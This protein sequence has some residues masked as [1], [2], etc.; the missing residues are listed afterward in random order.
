MTTATSSNI[1]QAPPSTR[2]NWAQK[3]TYMRQQPLIPVTLLLLLL[4]MCVFILYPIYQIVSQSVLIDGRFSLENYI[5]FFSS[6]FFQHTLYNTVVISVIATISAVVL[7]F[8]FA[9]GITRTSMPGKKF[10]MLI[11]I[12]PLI[13]PPFF[14]AFAFILLLGRQGI[15]NK[16]LF[17][18]FGVR[19]IIFGWQGVVLAQTIML[20][21]IAFLNLSAALGSIDPRMEEAAEDMGATFGVIMRRVTLPLLIPSLFSSAILIFMFNL[22][23]FGIPAIL[24]SSR[25]IWEDGSMLAPEAII[26]I[27][28]VFN[29]GM[30]AALAMVMLIPSFI[31][32]IFQDW[33]VRRRSYITVTGIPTSYPH[34]LAPKSVK[35][36]GFTIC[37][38]AAFM[39][40][41]IYVVVFMGAITRTW[42]V[43]YTLTT[44][45]I[46]LMLKVGL[47]SIRNSLVLSMGG[48]L[49]ASTLGV[50]IAFVLSRWEFPGK[51]S[52]Q[53]I[54]MLPYALPGVVMGLGFAVGF[55]SGILV[56]TGTWMIII[57]N[58]AI[59]R[60]PFSIESN[61]SAL[62]QIDI[63][64]EEAAA[65]MGASWVTTFWQIVLP[66]LRPTFIAALAFSFI[67]E[68]TDIT[69]VI[70][71]VSP[72]WRLLSIDIYNN[73]TAGRVGVAS[74]MSAT[75][76]VIV[77][78]VL[79]IIWRVS[80]LG[81]RMFK[82]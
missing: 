51:R 82:L 70:F 72:H 13:T 25:L 36:V 21:P 8:V 31:L 77:I 63:T 1:S 66:L 69:A 27:L 10:F 62:A 6:R 44:R 53:F 56:L 46:E 41:S 12:L 45:H 67:K 17:S 50:L 11:S 14:S 23:S 81:Y 32:F 16:V 38:L 33:Y 78:G 19:W 52:F 76:V 79:A 29:W 39:V 68:M 73:I 49:I 4:M 26:Q 59:R 9:F 3:Y 75:M 58:F 18:L 28:G 35:W 64:L 40:I 48:A 30:G 22:S 20:F 34:R 74:A 65:D 71:L 47:N 43:D 37:S 57:L 5:T 80:G 2:K 54:A 7:G 55:N 24:G 60:M 42:G 61:K 15:F